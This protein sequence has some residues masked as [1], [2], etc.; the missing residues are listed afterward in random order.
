MTSDIY[1]L[2]PFARIF[3]IDDGY[4]IYAYGQMR[5]SA[6]QRSFIDLLTGGSPL[7]ISDLRLHV[8]DSRIAEMRQKHILLEGQVPPTSGRHSR[9][10]G[11]YSMMSDDFGK[12]HDRVSQADVLLL[13]AGAVGSHILWNLAA[14][15]VRK[16]TVVDFD[17]VEDSN[18]NRQLLYSPCDIGLPKVDVVRRKMAE[19]NPDIELTVIQE[20]ICGPADIEK[21][22]AGKTVAI[23]A[24]DTP[25]ESM[26]WMNQA[27]VKYGV[28]YITGGV[29]AEL[30]VVGPAYLPGKTV[31][32]ACLG[33]ARVKKISGVGPTFTSLT[34]IVGA[35][36]SMNVF[37]IIVGATANLAN[38]LFIYN[39]VKDSWETVPL[40][41][42]KPCTVCGR[43]PEKP[44]KPAKR[45]VSGIAAYRCAI[46]SMML[47]AGGLRAF[48]HDQHPGWIVLAGLV[49]SMPALDLICGKKPEETQRQMFLTS[50]LY[51]VFALLILAFRGNLPSLGSPIAG[52]FGNVIGAVESWSLLVIVAAILITVLYFLLNGAMVAFKAASRELETWTS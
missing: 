5:F 8:A 24:F 39:V 29:M 27:C 14:M 31:C 32:S 1:H 17:V 30:G 34:A 25:E 36:I 4:S 40:V 49:L 52:A 15:G 41:T 45:G 3:Q 44:A 9:A 20:R 51:C 19:F 2:N 13:G 21:R 46:A 22:L 50:C 18:L 42:Q 28:P 23:R 43:E 12:V 48:T 6:R 37:R 47:L 26:E 38:K 11:F 10:L 16:I 33:S 35:S 7:S